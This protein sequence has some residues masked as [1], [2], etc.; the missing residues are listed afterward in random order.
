[1]T[2]SFALKK[3]IQGDKSQKINKK[4]TLVIDSLLKDSRLF[5]WCLYIHIHQQAEGTSKHAYPWGFALV[6]LKM[7]FQVMRCV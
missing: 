4:I 6:G 3:Q 7:K 2:I 1:M 5:F